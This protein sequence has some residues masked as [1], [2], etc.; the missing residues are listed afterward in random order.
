MKKVSKDTFESITKRSSLAEKVHQFADEISKGIYREEDDL[1]VVSTGLDDSA[2]RIA[3]EMYHMSRYLFDKYVPDVTSIPILQGMK[4]VPTWN[5]N[6]T[7][8]ETGSATV[9]S[10]LLAFQLLN[11]RNS[12]TLGSWKPSSMVEGTFHRV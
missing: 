3:D 6:L 2:C 1:E 8:Y 4:W 9:K 10:Y 11:M 7:W 5:K 12:R